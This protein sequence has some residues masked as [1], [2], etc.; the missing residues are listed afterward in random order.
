MD[1]TLKGISTFL[2]PR[3]IEY[4]SRS[5]YLPM[6][7]QVEILK[8]SCLQTLQLSENE[9][10]CILRIKKLPPIDLPTSLFLKI[11]KPKVL[12]RMIQNNDLLDPRTKVQLSLN[13]K[14]PLFDWFLRTFIENKPFLCKC[15]R[16]KD[17]YLIV[18]RE[19]HRQLVLGNFLFMCIGNNGIRCYK[20][21]NNMVVAFAIGDTIYYLEDQILSLFHSNFVFKTSY[22]IYKIGEE[23]TLSELSS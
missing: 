7:Q 22:S 5:L 21:S 4:L 23:R 14:G 2:S 13:Q 3:E 11:Y 17:I 10:Q 16:I 20:L 12:S 6:S 19:P 8:H 15:D 1:I 18:N 9:K